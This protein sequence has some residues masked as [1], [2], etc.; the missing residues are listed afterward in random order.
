[1]PVPEFINGLPLHA[2]LVH[3]VVVLLPLAVLGSVVIAVWPAGRQRYGWLVVAVTAV[4]TAL[5]PIATRSG[6]KLKERVA[7]QNNPLVNRHEELGNLM[8]RFAILLL[9]FVVA[10]MVVHEMAR[11]KEI[12]WAKVTIMVL[13]VLT[14]GSAVATGIHVYRV[15]DAGARATWDY[16]HNTPVK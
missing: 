9:V 8:L 10:L 2:L 16:V 5:V 11:R 4:A 7:G 13:A 1:M 3:F 6:A 14:I 12:R 15:G